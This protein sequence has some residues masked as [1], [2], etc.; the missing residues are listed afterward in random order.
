MAKLGWAI[1]DA[2]KCLIINWVVLN[3]L[4]LIKP[5][6]ESNKFFWKRKSKTIRE[7]NHQLWLAAWFFF[8]SEFFLQTK[9]ICLSKFI[10]VHALRVSTFKSSLINVTLFQTQFVFHLKWSSSLITILIIIIGCLLKA[11]KTKS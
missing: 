8:S 1:I 10:H 6:A 3:F 2:V 9:M 5:S 11:H 7:F 4:I